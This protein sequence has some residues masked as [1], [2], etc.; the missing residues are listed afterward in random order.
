KRWIKKHGYEARD[1]S[2]CRI[3]K[4]RRLESC[5]RQSLTMS[6]K[7]DS[8]GWGPGKF[9][10]FRDVVYCGTWEFETARFFYRK[11]IKYC[12]H[13]EFSALKYIDNGRVRHYTPDFYLPSENKYIEIKGRYTKKAKRKMELVINQNDINLE[14]WFAKDLLELGILS[15]GY[16]HLIKEGYYE[17]FLIKK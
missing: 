2:A 10:L 11:N 5:A 9:Y 3:G 14:I 15:K 6:T 17:E 13:G 8:I 16:Q 7:F 1:R 4:K 12:S